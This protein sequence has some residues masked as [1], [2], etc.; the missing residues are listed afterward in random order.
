MIRL[1]LRR[2]RREIAPARETAQEVNVWANPR[3]GAKWMFR[4]FAVWSVRNQLEGKGRDGRAI[5]APITEA[6]VTQEA[7]AAEVSREVVVVSGEVVAG[8]DGAGRVPRQVR[9]PVRRRR[10]N[11]DSR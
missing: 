11:G 7:I 4:H 9:L 8:A 10:W 5:S 6:A 3:I 1:A 2:D